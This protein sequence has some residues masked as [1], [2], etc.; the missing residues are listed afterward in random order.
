MSGLSS[1]FQTMPDPLFN[2]I[3]EII[4]AYDEESLENVM[5]FDNSLNILTWGIVH[6]D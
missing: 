2:E 1:Q 5:L 3:A 6:V 4:I